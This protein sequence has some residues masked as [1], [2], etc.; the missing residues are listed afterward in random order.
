MS[1]PFLGGALYLLL[2]AS[3]TGKAIMILPGIALMLFG[4][5]ILMPGIGDIF[6]G[7]FHNLLYP[8]DK[9]TK[10]PPIYGPAES[11]VKQGLYEE[12]IEAYEGIAEKHPGEAKPYL[13]MID[14]AAYRMQDVNRAD[15]MYQ[16][17]LDNLRDE[18]AV[19][20]LKK[21]YKGIRAK[22]ESDA[23]ITQRVISI[24][25]RTDSTIEGHSHE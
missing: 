20:I 19:V 2:M 17:G 13:E 16:Q 14:I 11:L 5:L 15:R 6:S 21:L 12:A 22:G 1:L 25:P 23:E 4:A 7:G 3:D 18:T 8:D 10:T 24:P 9:F